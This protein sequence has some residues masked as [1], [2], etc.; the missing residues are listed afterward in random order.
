M[1]FCVTLILADP[2]SVQITQHQTKPLSWLRY[3]FK[4]EDSKQL[5]QQV[6]LALRRVLLERPLT[7]QHIFQDNT[8]HHYAVLCIELFN[9]MNEGQSVLHPTFLLLLWFTDTWTHTSAE[10]LGVAQACLSSLLLSISYSTKAHTCEIVESVS[11]PI[12][13]RC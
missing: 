12:K 6:I 8:R 10:C 1:T 9:I 4:Q 5:P 2:V 3:L 11:D 13:K 7:I